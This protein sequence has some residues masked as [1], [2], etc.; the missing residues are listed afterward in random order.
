MKLFKLTI[1]LTALWTSFGLSFGAKDFSYYAA[2]VLPYALDADG[3]LQ[4]LLGLS[5]VHADQASDFGGL[6]DKIDDHYPQRT[7]ARE[8]CEELMFIFD[9]DPS[10]KRILK[11]RNSYGKYFD[12]VKVHSVSYNRLYAAMS[13]SCLSSLSDN[14]IM[15][16]I[17]IPYQENI[18]V[19]FQ[20]RKLMYK[21][22]L[23]HCWDETVRLVWVSVD[24]VFEAIAARSPFGPVVIK[25]FSLYEPFV[26]SL[27]VARS[28]GIIAQIKKTPL[29]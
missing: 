23:P 19:M 25:N 20:Q 28:Q 24:E 14:Y 5:S 2:G 11:L 27:I 15:H 29:R 8:G 12:M 6:Q 3:Q 26:K 9:T 4:F 10:F 7:A 1:L 13:K 21:G 22:L 16:F 18:P 17:A